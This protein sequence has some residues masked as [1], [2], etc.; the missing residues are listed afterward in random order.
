MATRAMLFRGSWAVSV[1]PAVCM[2]QRMSQ[3]RGFWAPKRSFISLAHI[4][5]AALILAIS[6]K[7]WLGADQKKES[8]GAKSS[9]LR[10]AST[11]A[12]TIWM[13]T[14]RTKPSS[15]TAVHPVSR[16]LYP[17]RLTVFHR[18]IS[19]VQKR[20]RSTVMRRL[21]R[22]GKD[23]ILE[24]MWPATELLVATPVSLDRGM[25]CLSPATMY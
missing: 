17:S 8:L 24:P 15:W 9:T 20:T 11:Q 1:Y 18:G 3:E 14:L 19:A 23:S 16:M 6:S 2:W 7:K 22:G 10:P 4:L 5:R 12:W 21:G 13:A 25:P